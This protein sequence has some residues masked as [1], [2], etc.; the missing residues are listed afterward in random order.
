MNKT[1]F[2]KGFFS[3][4]YIKKPKETLIKITIIFVP[5]YL[6]AYF[7]DNMVYVLPTLASTLLIGNGLE[8]Q[9]DDDTTE[10][11]PSE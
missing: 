6:V 3:S 2:N 10:G 5:T 9:E 7:I 8:K 4:L 11:D 1:Q